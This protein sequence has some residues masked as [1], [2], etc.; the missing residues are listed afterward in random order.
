MNKAVSH[1]LSGD[2]IRLKLL[3]CGI[4]VM[5]LMFLFLMAMPASSETIHVDGAAAEGGDG[6]AGAPYNTI[7]DAINSSKD[8]DT[9]QVQKG[10]YNETIVV[11][12]SVTLLGDNANDTIISHTKPRDLVTISAAWVNMSGF[13]IKGSPLHSGIVLISGHNTISG[14]AISGTGIGIFLNE[15]S[16]NT[17]QD[18]SFSSNT[19]DIY[20]HNASH[21]TVRDGNSTGSIYGIRVNNNSRSNTISDNLITTFMTGIHSEGQGTAIENNSC[22]GGGY[23]IYLSSSESSLVA[24]NNCTKNA[25]AG[26]R[27]LDSGLSVL[28]SNTITDS[29]ENGIQLESSAHSVIGNNTLVGTEGYVA[30][31]Y[32]IWISSSNNSFLVNNSCSGKEVYGIYLYASGNSTLKDNSFSGNPFAAISIHLSPSCTISGNTNTGPN[33]TAL[34]LSTSDNSLLRENTISRFYLFSGNLT[35]VGN[36]LGNDGGIVVSGDSLSFWNTHSIDTTNTVNGKP[37]YY[38][39]NREGGTVPADAGQ[40]ILA[41]CTGM[42]VENLSFTNVSVP[43]TLGFSSGIMVRSNDLINC[44]SGGI[45]LTESNENTITG[46]MIEGTYYC[47]S[48]RDSEGNLISGNHFSNGSYG[49]HLSSSPYNNITNNSIAGNSIGIY[50]VANSLDNRIHYNTITA[51]KSYGIF[52]GIYGQEEVLATYNWWGHASGPRNSPGNPDGE[53]DLIMDSV[54]FSHWLRKERNEPQILGMATGVV[55][56]QE[57]RARFATLNMNTNTLSWSMETN[58]SFL[59]FDSE[60]AVLLGTPSTGGSYWVALT[61]DDKA[62]TDSYNFTMRVMAVNDDP[63]ITIDSFMDVALQ[64][65]VNITGTMYD[66]EGPVE[67][68]QISM[69]GSFYYQSAILVNE[70][71]WYYIIDTTEHENGNYTIRVRGFDGTK[72]S[73][74]VTTQVTIDNTPEEDEPDSLVGAVFAL[75]LLGFAVGFMCYLFISAYK[76]K[77]NGTDD[78][79]K[80]P[81]IFEGDGM[82]RKDYHGERIALAPWREQDNDEETGDRNDGGAGEEKGKEDENA[83]KGISEDG[84]V[85]EPSSV[86]DGAEEKADEKPKE[87]EEEKDLVRS[88]IRTIG[89]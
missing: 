76:E 55:E 43:I 88:Y 25:Y 75:G 6:S 2:R 89:P 70:T 4:L 32:G 13:G 61:A 15:S 47:V 36:T 67:R 83:S 64:R 84:G 42:E 53:G 16:H 41:N 85:G 79:K 3:L 56:E 9:I 54:D 28:E 27:L 66:E 8:G 19:Y 51:S 62:S 10:G 38:Y 46:T 35:L 30:G 78:G 37:V 81:G 45:S 71:H 34:S 14:N 87:D 7:Q 18:N 17:L 57:Y 26:I 23:G 63:V 1:S 44:R 49:L 50:L 21:N 40:V 20:I 39:R 73:D 31:S 22:E 60:N 77:D 82:E 29:G 72:Y 5:T 59:D 80:K 33:T 52:A 68:V 65:V 86:G 69:D 12:R 58:A 24:N 48:L 74:F 11:D